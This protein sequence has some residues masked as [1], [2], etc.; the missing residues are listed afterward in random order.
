[1]PSPNIQDDILKE[2]EIDKLPPE[3]REEILTA[4]TEL[5]LKRLTVR[6]LEN[7]HEQQQEEFSK[8]SA[9]GDPEK[10]NQ[11]FVA[12]VPDYETIIQEEI[13]LFKKEM[14]ETI[15]ALLV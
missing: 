5:L 9:S 14:K 15:D 4:M 6:V 11:F 12:N 3:K 2:L 7:L 1:M 10:I 13:A 8:I